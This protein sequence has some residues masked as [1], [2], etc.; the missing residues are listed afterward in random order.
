MGKR[1]LEVA[2]RT[3]PQRILVNERTI[4]FRSAGSGPAIV[5]I[6]GMVSSSATWNRVIG[7]LSA[8]ARVVAPD[9]PGHGG[10]S[11]PGGDH[12]LGAMASSIRD[13]M[14]ALEIPRA[15]F[16][17]HSLG[18]GV[19]MQAAY[20]FPER[21]ERLVLVG[22][23]GLGREVAFL[24]RALSLPGAELVLALGCSPRAVGAAR[25]VVR[26]LR[27]LGLRPTPA[28]AEIGRGYDSLVDPDARNALLGT[29][30]AVIGLGGQRVSAT[31]R[32]ALAA[33]LPTLIVW[34]EADSIIPVA[35]AHVSHAAIPGSRLEI[36]PDVGHFPQ[37]EKPERL[38]DVLV[39]FIGSTPPASFTEERLRGLLLDART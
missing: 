33:A 11:N 36:L 3:T 6:H 4:A 16:V 9:L 14:V 23:G 1:G 12:S 10:S 26:A 20:Q 13:L 37:A 19:A 27:R 30:R 24:L 38:A 22:S 21:C 39:D 28:M 35:H 15:T 25:S 7:P 29:V 2:E 32:L 18:G 8:H 17:G 34:G 31:D 5:L